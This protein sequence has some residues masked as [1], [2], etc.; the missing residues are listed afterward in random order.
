MNGRH[1]FYRTL[2]VAFTLLGLLVLWQVLEVIVVL[3]AAIIFA[4][5]IRPVV[6]WLCHRGLPQGLAILLV[7]LLIFGG[8]IGLL[9]IAIPPLVGVIGELVAEGSILARVNELI[10]G[11][12]SGLGYQEIAG[13]IVGRLIREWN[14]LG[15]RLGAFAAEEGPLL[16][17]GTA[18]FL[19]QFLLGM[20][21]SFYW[22]TA[23][24]NIQSFLI[25][26]T[27]VR[28]RGQL[29][30]IFNDVEHT[31]GDWLRGTGLL[32]L[33]IGVSSFVGLLLLGVPYA[34]PLA[35]IAGLFEAIPMVGATL[36]AVP[37][38]LV[39]FT[40]SPVHGLLT[41]LLFM[42]IQFLENN[43]LVPRIME[44]SVG[45][46]PLLVLIAITAGGLL[47]GMV[48]ALLAIP[49]VAALQIIVRNLVVEPMVEEA[50]QRTVEHGIPIFELDEEADA[51]EIA[52]AGKK[53]KAS[54]ILVAR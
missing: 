48:G 50:S 41:I 10:I 8:A 25:S 14:Q 16:L 42:L 24:D 11:I 51:E 45:M 4:S 22:L 53:K 27:P 23:R 12:A 2:I 21:M 13:N 46:N 5:A 7:Y 38:V 35:L 17:R 6:A 15:T 39:A 26:M 44:R 18:I 47:N 37:A 1:T 40:I 28:H 19:G 54:E 49:L 32:M 20:V 36:G 9:A 29:E 34:L 52:E 31:M 43:I 30:T 3:L 33:S